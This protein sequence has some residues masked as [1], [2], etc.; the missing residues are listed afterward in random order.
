VC[1]LVREDDLYCANV[2][3]AEAVLFTE[4]S[5]RPGTY[6]PDKLT[7]L[8]RPSVDTER[9]RITAAG[10]HV[11]FNRVGG[12]LAISRALGD[13]AFKA[14][15]TGGDEV[16]AEPYIVYRKVRKG[17]AVLVIA[18]DGLWDVLSAEDVADRVATYK[19][20]CVGAADAAQ[21]LVSAALDNNTT[22]NVTCI[23]AYINKR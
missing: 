20:N 14:P 10:G 13:G 3:D 11:V 18:C 21:M 5:R 1:A 7:Q 9:R 17:E 22:D 12:V 4:S 15:L 23:V 8:H 16:S 2:G 19:Y 6:V